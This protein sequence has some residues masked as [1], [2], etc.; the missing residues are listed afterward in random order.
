MTNKKRW[1][2]PRVLA[3]GVSVVVMSLVSFSIWLVVREDPG[4]WT[5]GFAISHFALVL[6]LW[7]KVGWGM[8][9]ASLVLL[10]FACPTLLC[11]F[12]LDW[13]GWR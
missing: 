8:S 13:G 11:L 10:G 5:T 2:W 4:W 6:G 9:R 3:V 7:L 12:F 1:T